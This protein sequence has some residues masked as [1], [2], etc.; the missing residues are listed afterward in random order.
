[1]QHTIKIFLLAA[2]MGLAAGMLSCKKN[3]GTGYNPA[4]P[5][6][7]DSFAAASGGVGTE[8]LISGSNFSSDT[9]QVRVF[10]NGHQL[11]LVGAS[12]RQLMAVVPAKCGSGNVIV[13]IGKDSGVSKGIFNYTFSRVV[14]T[15]A[16][17]GRAGYADGDAASAEFN[18][19]GQNWYRSQG[20]GVDGDLNVY[21]ADASTFPTFP[22]FNPTLTIMANALR[23]AR[24]MTTNPGE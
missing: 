16:G 19:N 8:V 20:I 14:S 15:L 10:I 3:N 23:I 13:K 22:G 9:S 17:D 1:M 12:G 2:F 21:V 11:T 5:I 24:R 4:A 18:F 6:V 7:I